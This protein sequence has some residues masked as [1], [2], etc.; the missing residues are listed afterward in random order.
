MDDSEADFEAW[1]WDAGSHP[2]ILY[3][4]MLADRERMRVYREAIEAAV[5]PGDIVADLGT[6]LGVLALMAVRAGAEQVYAIDLKPASIWLAKR[7]A[8]A[9]G[10]IDRVR[11]IQGDVRSISLERPV[12]V[13]VN[14]L[15]G[16]FGTD[17]GIHE[18]V[19]AFATRNLAP[20]GRIVPERL[21]TRLVPVEYGPDYRGV[22][23]EDNEGIDLRPALQLPYT[24]RPE[25]YTL[26]QAPTELARPAPVEDIEFAPAMRGDRRMEVP[27]QFEVDRPGSL[28]GFV[29]S[30]RCTLVPGLVLDTWPAYPGCHWHHWHWPVLPPVTVAPGDRLAGRL[31]MRVD[32]S[33]AMGWALEWEGP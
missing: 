29:G 16:N 17:E 23:G 27:L 24:P 14:E 20:G 8:A 6:G 19:R 22:F 11:F 10:V 33:G 5:R 15:I 3:Q 32:P 4:D 21:E 28:Q 25:L 1:V 31:R 26:R 7:I 12:D 30:F 18:S 13:I 9:N 2:A